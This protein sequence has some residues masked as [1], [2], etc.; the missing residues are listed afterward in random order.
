MLILYLFL[1][2]TGVLC[3][4]CL[5]LSFGFAN[6]QYYFFCS[7]C[8]FCCHKLFVGIAKRQMKKKNCKRKKSLVRRELAIALTSDHDQDV[9]QIEIELQTDSIEPSYHKL[10]H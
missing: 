4:V 2:I 8:H 7:K 6:K 5:W 9:N 3:P 10:E 1:Q